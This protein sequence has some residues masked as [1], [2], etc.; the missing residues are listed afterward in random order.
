MGNVSGVY[1]CSKSVN[2]SLSKGSR[3]IKMT[4]RK[5]NIVRS[6]F[7]VAAH[8]LQLEVLARIEE[9]VVILQV[10]LPISSASYSDQQYVHANV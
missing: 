1:R 10:I 9:D 5:A 6:R 3:P 2:P 8:W 4:Y 7:I